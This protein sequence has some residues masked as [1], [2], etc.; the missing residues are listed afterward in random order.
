M[1]DKRSGEKQKGE[2]IEKNCIFSKENVNMGHQPEFDYLKTLGVFCI[3][4][5]H[6]YLHYNI[7]GYLYSLVYYLCTILTAGA[8]MILMGANM[9]YSRHHEPHDYFARSFVLFTMGQYLNLIRN[10][11][12][13]VI[14][15]WATGSNKFIARALLVLQTD[16]LTFAGFAFL[17]LGILKKMKLSDNCILLISIIMNFVSLPLFNIMKQP[18]NYLL[19]QILGFFVLTNAEAYFSIFG[20]FIFVAFGYWIAGFYQKMLNKDKFYNRIL[21]ICFPIVAIYQYFRINDRIPILTEYNSNV[22]YCLSPGPDAIH[23]IMSNMV[24]LAIFY[25]IDKAIGKTPEFISHCGKNL[26]QY[27]MISFIITMQMNAFLKATRGEKYTN[28]MKYMD[29]FG[30]ILM[31][32]SRILIDINDKYIHFTISTLKNPMRNIVFALIWIMTIISIIY[33]YPKV[34]VYANV[35]NDYL[36]EFE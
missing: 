8:L 6:V 7:N 13:N 29:L 11:L 9:R 3:T 31:F 10:C 23:R 12:P 33:I 15:Y 22:H 14:A 36:Y 19:S 25:K 30:F 2:I 34:E 32:I 35:W 28:T 18:D 1:A 26:N 27:Y 16:I 20:Y 4:T 21:I 24:I 17:L 5:A